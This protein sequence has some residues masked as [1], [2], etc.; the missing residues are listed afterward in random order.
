MIIIDEAV[1]DG[2]FHLANVARQRVSQMT[3]RSRR[4]ADSIGLGDGDFAEP[5]AEHMRGAHAKTRDDRF[6]RRRDSHRARRAANWRKP[7]MLCRSMAMVQE[8]GGGPIASEPVLVHP[9]RIR[10]QRRA[11]DTG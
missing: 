6:G 9:A 3:R 10:S 1:A 8:P 4:P 2:E 7:K 5:A 11:A